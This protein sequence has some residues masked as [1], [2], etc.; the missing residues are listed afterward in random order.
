MSGQLQIFGGGRTNSTLSLSARLA[1]ISAMPE[2]G[3]GSTGKEVLLSPTQS[4]SLL[5]SDQSFL[6]GKMLRGHSP[7]TLARIFGQLSKPLPN[8]GAIDLNGN[9]LIQHGFYPKIESGFTLSDF[10]EKSVAEKYFLS[11]KMID[12]LTT[13]S[14]GHWEFKPLDV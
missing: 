7:Q 14:P 6:S 8:L 5:R 12:F 10:L 11:Q 1:K 4:G 2:L 9:C 3:G 13:E